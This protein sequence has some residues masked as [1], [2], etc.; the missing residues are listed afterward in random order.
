MDHLGQHGDNARD[1]LLDDLIPR[2]LA[3]QPGDIPLYC[4][5]LLSKLVVDLPRDGRPLL[6]PDIL[7]IRRQ[8]PQVLLALPDLL[9]GIFE[10]RNIE[11]YP[12]GTNF[13]AITDADA[14]EIERDPAAIPRCQLSFNFRPAGEKDFLCLL[15]DKLALGPREEVQY[16]HLRKLVMRITRDLFTLV[17]PPKEGKRFIVHIEHPRQ[18]VDDR[19]GKQLF[20]PKRLFRFF[21]QLFFFEDLQRKRN[22]PDDL[23]QHP[24]LFLIKKMY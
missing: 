6:L 4:R 8:I 7:Q 22:V 18:E 13:V 17:V 16:L 20:G 3:V 24:D 12:K 21:P 19:V 14:A 11:T 2:D 23:I 10:P 1:A 9:L 5:E 15:P